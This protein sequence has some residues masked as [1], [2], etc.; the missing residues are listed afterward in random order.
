MEE[1]S[2]FFDVPSKFHLK[3]SVNIADFTEKLQTSALIVQLRAPYSSVVKHEWIW[4]VKNSNFSVR[5]N[6]IQ[7]LWPVRLGEIFSITRKNLIKLFL[8]NN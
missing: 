1:K 6:R 5:E 7:R 8:I 4:N 2:C 3:S